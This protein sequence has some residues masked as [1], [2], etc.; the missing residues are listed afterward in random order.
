MD[1]VKRIP[2]T[3]LFISR[4]HGARVHDGGALALGAYL[5]D[6]RQRQKKREDPGRTRTHVGLSGSC[7]AR[8]PRELAVATRR[9]VSRAR[10]RLV[11]MPRA[12]PKRASQSRDLSP[13]LKRRARS[14]RPPGGTRAADA[15]VAFA[16]VVR[17]RPRAGRPP[18]ARRAP[19]DALR[20]ARRLPRRAALARAA[21]LARAARGALRR[22]HRAGVP[23]R[24]PRADRAQRR[25]L[26]G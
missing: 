19:R 1:S 15:S 3:W 17:A 12:W 21:P 20:P 18:G 22:G 23:R 5:E 9:S 16:T 14:R 7:C 10:L 4:V 8:A 6:P 24:E 2:A 25:E 11:S 26:R 13:T